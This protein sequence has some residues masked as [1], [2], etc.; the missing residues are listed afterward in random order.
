MEGHIRTLS[1]FGECL[2][3]PTCLAIEVDV[4]PAVS[5]WQCLANHQNVFVQSRAAS[6]IPGEWLPAMLESEL[7]SPMIPMHDSYP[8]ADGRSA[9][10]AEDGNAVHNP[11]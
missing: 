1:D 3:E 11:A 6:S 4:T 7:R 9:I 8:D 10:V 5:D 2:P